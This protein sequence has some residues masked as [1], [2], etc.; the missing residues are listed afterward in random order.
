MIYILKYLE[1]R[2]NNI[3]NIYQITMV[4]KMPTVSFKTIIF[5][6]METL[7]LQTATTTTAGLKQGRTL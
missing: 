1:F 3:L 6:A 5:T 7:S 4:E 2:L